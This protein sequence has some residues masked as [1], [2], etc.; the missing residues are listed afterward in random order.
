MCICTAEEGVGAHKRLGVDWRVLVLRTSGNLMSPRK[1]A[2]ALNLECFHIFF[3]CFFKQR[4]EMPFLC[5][6]SSLGLGVLA[7]LMPSS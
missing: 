2:C 1:A 4:D 7:E 3:M 5:V 6:G